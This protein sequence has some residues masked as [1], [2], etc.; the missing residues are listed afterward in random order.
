ML[1]SQ[2]HKINMIK[3]T[4]K[5]R[6]DITDKEKSQKATEKRAIKAKTERNRKDAIENKAHTL[7]LKLICKFFGS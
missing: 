3:N 5:S 4:K 6:T 1:S 2:P 7:L